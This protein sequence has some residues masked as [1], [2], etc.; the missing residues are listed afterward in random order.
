[1]KRARNTQELLSD[2]LTYHKFI[3]TMVTVIIDIIKF[4]LV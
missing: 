2:I 3:D 1:M 4:T